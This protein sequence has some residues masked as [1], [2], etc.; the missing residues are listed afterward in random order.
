[1]QINKT[2]HMPNMQDPKDVNLHKLYLGMLQAK[3]NR[4][5]RI[6]ADQQEY[7]DAVKDLLID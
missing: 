3:Q 7:M 1:M 2:E 5:M 6:S 4:G